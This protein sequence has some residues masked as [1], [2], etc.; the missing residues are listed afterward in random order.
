MIDRATKIDWSDLRYVDREIGRQGMHWQEAWAEDVRAKWNRW[1]KRM[2]KGDAAE[3]QCRS[4]EW[5]GSPLKLEEAEVIHG[6]G[7]VNKHCRRCSQD[8]ANEQVSRW[9]AGT[10]D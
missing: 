8:P 5:E 7:N 4:W 2:V 10:V 3:E 6:N 1:K 9:G